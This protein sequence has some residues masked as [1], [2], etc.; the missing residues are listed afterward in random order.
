MTAGESANGALRRVL[1][2][3]GFWVGVLIV[4]LATSTCIAL[5]FWQL[6]RFDQKRE[7]AAVIEQNYGAA[8]APLATALPQPDAALP[9]ARDWTPVALHGRYCTSD[10]C[11]LYVRNRTFGGDV[12]FWQLVPFEDAGSGRT[13]L[14]V[15]G[16]V[17][18]DKRES[19]P[20]DPPRVPA[21]EVTVTAHLRPAE[22]V[23]T[24]RRN[25]PGQVQSVAP[26]QVAEQLGEA[27]AAPVSG[28]YAVMDREDPAVSRPQP[29]PRPETDLGPHLSYAFQWW[30][31]ALFFPIGLFA[32]TRT[33]WREE[34]GEAAGAAR[35]ASQPAHSPADRSPAYR[36]HAA[37][38]RY[39]TAA[40]DAESPGARG[41]A[42]TDEEEEDALIDDSRW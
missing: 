2:S 39:G 17:A 23:L 32:W 1:L 38:G 37:R 30:I 13:I 26:D 3:R 41:R 29:L 27:S 25:P 10:D 6:G 33:R 14:V 35:R 20:A 22:G 18:S 40:G 11:V 19:V 34:R 16:W 24:S 12:G 7:R 31:F 4:A 28:A 42:R 21:G 36:S 15:R 9:A 8:P 5:G